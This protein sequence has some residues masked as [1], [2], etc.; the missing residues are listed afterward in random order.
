MSKR[1]FEDFDSSVSLDDVEIFLDEDLLR[2][3]GSV[4]KVSSVRLN[5]A[6]L[7]TLF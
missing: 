4:N 1:P 2:G 7:R 5:D 3:E 6:P